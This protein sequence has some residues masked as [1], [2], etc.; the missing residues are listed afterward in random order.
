MWLKAFILQ[1]KNCVRIISRVRRWNK[2][3][4]FNHMFDVEFKT[5]EHD[6][7]QISFPIVITEGIGK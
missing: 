4:D 1:H 2:K 5:A 7:K 6:K 3:E